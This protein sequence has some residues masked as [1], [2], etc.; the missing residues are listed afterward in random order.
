VRRMIA[1]LNR[2]R[3]A[4]SH[5]AIRNPHSEMEA[6]LVQTT[7]V[8]LTPLLEIKSADVSR[9][10]TPRPTSRGSAAAPVTGP[11]RSLDNRRPH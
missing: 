5:S 3:Y 7:L 10:R 8:S 4:P 9:I 11:L 1:D 2:D 6:C